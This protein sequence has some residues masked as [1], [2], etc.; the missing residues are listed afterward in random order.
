MDELL[1]QGREAGVL[2]HD[3]AEFMGQGASLYDEPVSL[4]VV[5]EMAIQLLVI[6]DDG[7]SFRCDQVR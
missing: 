1:G 7:K 4:E 3:P 2:P 6:G 5:A